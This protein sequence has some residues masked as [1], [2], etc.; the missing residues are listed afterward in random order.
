MNTGRKFT[1]NIL[2]KVS[3]TRFCDGRE[4][5]DA[6]IVYN[7]VNIPHSLKIIFARHSSQCFFAV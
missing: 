2:S 4:F 3:H 1:D 6:G 7:D 5:T